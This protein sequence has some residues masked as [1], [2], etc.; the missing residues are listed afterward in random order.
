MRIEK[1]AP[2]SITKAVAILKH[3]GVVVYPTE[4]AYALG[5]DATNG[6]AIAKI[7]K[8][9]NRPK[10]KGLPVICATKRMASDF[11]KF[12]KIER[13]LAK[14][15][16]PGPLTMVLKKSSKFKVQSLKFIAVRVSPNKV[17]CA[18]SRG[19]KR[20]IVSTSA[21]ISGAAAIYNSADIIKNFSEKKYQPDL[22]L[23]AGKIPVRRPSTIIKIENNKVIILRQGEVRI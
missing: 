12:G 23:D 3:G 19:L 4:T 1:I 7:F 13:K 20:P 5:C 22:I 16:W 8:I 21:N 17:A 18:I 14:K 6:K 10:E 15:Y 2:E 9:K 11:F